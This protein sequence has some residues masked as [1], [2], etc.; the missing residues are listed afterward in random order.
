MHMTEDDIVKFCLT[1][2]HAKEDQVKRDLANI[3]ILIFNNPQWHLSVLI[4]DEDRDTVTDDDIARDMEQ[5]I[6]NRDVKSI[7]ALIQ[8]KPNLPWACTLYNGV[9]VTITASLV[10]ITLTVALFGCRWMYKR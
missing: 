3:E 9:K 7:V 6:F 4:L 2:F 1:N 5:V 8:L 10:I